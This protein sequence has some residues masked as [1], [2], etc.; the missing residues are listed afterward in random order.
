MSAKGDAKERWVME[1]LDENRWR[2]GRNESS[3]DS[4]KGDA[5]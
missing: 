1:G 2:K 3:G 5:M 4:S